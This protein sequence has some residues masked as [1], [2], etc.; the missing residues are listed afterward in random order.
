MMRTQAQIHA[1]ASAQV[2]SADY[3]PFGTQIRSDVIRLRRTGDYVA[4]WRL[5]GIS[6]ETADAD[7]I[8][9]R[10]DSLNNYLRSLGGGHQAIWSHKVRRSV[11][12]RLQG[13][14]SNEFAQQFSDRYYASFDARSESTGQLLHPQMV[15]ELYVTLIYR[16]RPSKVSRMFKRLIAR[17]AGEIAERDAEDLDAFDDLAKQM[18]ASLRRYAPERL[19]TFTRSGTVFSEMAAFFGFLVNGVWED[20]PLRRAQLAEYL[21]TSRLHFGD[22]NGMLEIWHP[23]ARK[24]AGFLDFQDYPKFSEPG[25][26]NA[27]L[28]GD[29]EYIETQSF[30]ILS[31]RDAMA[32]LERQQ[33]QLTS[34]EDASETE[35]VA[36]SAAMEDL[37]SGLIEMGEYHYTLAVFGSSLN[38]VAKNMS[39]ARTSLQDGPDFKMAVIDAIPECAWFAQLPGN[40]S[41]R[42]REA[43]ITSRNFAGLS[44]FHNFSRGKRTGN[45]WGEALALMQTPSGQPYYFNHHVSADDHDATDEKKP[46]NTAV[47]GQIGVGK[48]TLVLGLLLFALKYEG[49]RGVFFDK[50]R[51]AEIAIRRLGGKYNALKRGQPT[52]FNP[53]QLAPTEHNVGFCEKFVRLLVGAGPI[54]QMAAEDSEIS[55]AVRTVMSDTVHSELRRLSA[56]WQ[57]LKVLQGGNSV[58]DRLVKWIGNH[59]HGWAFDNPRDTQDLSDPAIRIHGYDYTEFLDDVEIRTPMMA[60]LLHITESLING[61]PFIY[62]MEEFWK[63]LMDPYFADFALNKQKTIR[64][65]SGLGVFITQSPSDVLL[66]PIGKTMVEQSVTK[67]F[68][69]NPS[70]DRHDYVDGFKVTE[71]E[72]DII[73]NLGEDSRLFLVKQGHRSAIMKFDLGGMPDILN[74]LSGSLDNVELLET[75]RQEL[76]DDPKAWEPEFHKRIASRRAHIPQV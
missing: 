29:Y 22:K 76:G 69:P 27:I 36:M 17:T 32:A 71:Q 55:S 26:N 2:P 9:E 16:P 25:I 30:S 49:V 28:Y 59:Q 45:P 73:R 60:Y 15:T 13:K 31:K 34:A 42:P 44:P 75:I 38:E 6:F 23:L 14:F 56:V 66:H 48:T 21:P 12:E 74:I 52:G 70:A 35:I 37:A 63:P 72:F 51:G 67:I 33:G 20:I 54:D 10:H 46:G 64:K 8:Q 39:E 11:H 50:D 18:Q 68:L 43:S 57:N 41:M 3:I 53:F 4:T 62:W 24:F 65:Q 61:Q 19:A 40:W 5:E 7:F 47:I 58:R 1:S